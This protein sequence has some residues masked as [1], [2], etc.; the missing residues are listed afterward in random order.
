MLK[1]LKT[2]F[3]WPFILNSNAR[4][5]TV[6]KNRYM[7]LSCF[8]T[9]VMSKSLWKKIFNWKW[10]VFKIINIDNLIQIFYQIIKLFGHH[11]SLCIWQS[12][13]HWESHEITHLV[14]LRR[15]FSS[16]MMKFCELEIPFFWY[17]A[18]SS[19][20]SFKV[21]LKQASFVVQQNTGKYRK[22]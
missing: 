20:Y 14:T 5:T 19:F 1:I 12:S 22:I 21:T 11:Y 6:P 7:I 4:L 3:K 17:R 10:L 8:P 16:K 2:N 13:L 18:R 9:V 15:V